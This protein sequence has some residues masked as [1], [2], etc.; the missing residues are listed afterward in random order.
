MIATMM[1]QQHLFQVCHGT[2]KLSQVHRIKQRCASIMG[3]SAT[4]RL[5]QRDDQCAW[6]A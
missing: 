2:L 5:V 6:G 4:A 3:N 1:V